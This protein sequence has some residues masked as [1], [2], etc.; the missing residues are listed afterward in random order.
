MDNNKEV[1]IYEDALM[2]ICKKQKL[3]KMLEKLPEAKFNKIQVN[4]KYFVCGIKGSVEKTLHFDVKKAENFPGDELV[5]QVLTIDEQGFCKYETF[6]V[7]HNL[8]YGQ[9]VLTHHDDLNRWIG[10]LHLYDE[11]KEINRLERISSVEF[12]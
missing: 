3:P 5:S 7:P 1:N 8:T 12:L 4:S 6:E 2:D 10:T 11:E 9:I